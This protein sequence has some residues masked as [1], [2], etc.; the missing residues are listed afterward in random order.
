MKATRQSTTNTAILRHNAVSSASL[1]IRASERLVAKRKRPGPTSGTY[2]ASGCYEFRLNIFRIIYSLQFDLEPGP[3]GQR[4]Q[5]IAPLDRRGQSPNCRA[6]DKPRVIDLRDG[7][8]VEHRRKTFRI[9]KLKAYRDALT[10]EP[11]PAAGDGY[12]YQ[13]HKSSISEA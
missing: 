10:E 7:D 12:A 9:E 3:D 8:L 1:R 4:R 2:H 6:V 11:P 13:T 5:L